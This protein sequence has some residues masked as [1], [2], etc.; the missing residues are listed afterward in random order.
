MDTTV[1]LNFFWE[2]TWTAWW[3]GKRADPAT[4]ARLHL[5]LLRRARDIGFAAWTAAGAYADDGARE[6]FGAALESAL[7]EN[8][9]AGGNR[10]D[11]LWHRYTALLAAGRVEEAGFVETMLAYPRAGTPDAYPAPPVP[12]GGHPTVRAWEQAEKRAVM[13]GIRWPDLY[14]ETPFT[15]GFPH[16]QIIP[17]EL[18]IT[19]FAFAALR[20]ALGGRLPAGGAGSFEH[21]VND[22]VTVITFAW[23]A[24]KTPDEQTEILNA[25]YPFT[26]EEETLDAFVGIF[27]D[28]ETLL[29]E[30]GGLV[31]RGFADEAK[32]VYAYTVLHTDDPALHN[33]AY[34]NLAVL[35]REEGEYEKAAGCAEKALAIREGMADRDLF[36]IAI[37]K[38][39]LAEVLYLAGETERA[40]SLT[41]AALD[42][43]GGIETGK[44]AT[45][46][47]AMASSFRR[48]G[49]FEEEYAL[50]TRI[51]DLDVQGEAT[52]AAVERLFSM[53]QY[54]RPDGTFD[55]K[56]LAAV[57]EKRRYLDLFG[58]G[59]VLLQA[60]QFDR[61]IRCFEAALAISRDTDLLRN[62]AIAHRLYGSPDAARR[63]LEEVL[64]ARPGDLYALMHL[65]LLKG[66]EEGGVHIREAIGRALDAGADLALVLYPL[67]SGLVAGPDDTVLPGIERFGDLPS[68]DG[69]R[70]LYFLGAGTILSDL[71]CADAAATCY[72][73]ALKANP[74]AAVRGRVLRNMG[75]LAADGSDPARAAD[76]LGQA[77]KFSPE[78]PTVW[79][80]L[81]GVRAALGDAG[82]AAAAAREAVRLLPTDA[83]F[84][85]EKALRE[86][87]AAVAPRMPADRTAAA[88]VAAAERMIEEEG[89]APLA[90]RAYAAAVEA[91]GGEAPDVPAPS[92][93]DGALAAR[94]RLIAALNRA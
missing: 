26:L 48:T 7:S 90:L 40:R 50:L 10:A 12:A 17:A 78:D 56:G 46:L 55:L 70:A 81:A 16:T 92:G 13:A 49:R 3:T 5:F 20:D 59:A 54:A 30:A 23:F 32:T 22:A 2:Q 58:K 25:A 91:A 74:P 61:A 72:R 36:A 45:L 34:E 33:V 69:A 80:R 24:A 93:Y 42:A 27:D 68:H 8:A 71:G 83:A 15:T 60:F 31:K 73:R 87:Q 19:S 41:V 18:E 6:A 84:R 9:P 39:N 51:L 64:A 82:G 14:F 11:Y 1:A 76:L 62:I 53:D 65:G 63:Y 67:V 37:A 57:E 4:A 86:A 28:Y 66:G 29:G 47:W 35:F 75:A 43:A 94:E 77:L 44:A 85:R 21:F 88:L 52:D 79:H 38:K 89:S